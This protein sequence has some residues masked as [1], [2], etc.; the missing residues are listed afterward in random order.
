MKQAI[1]IH[2]TGG[3]PESF[4]TPWLKQQLTS[5]GYKVHTPQMPD[6]DNPRLDTWLP[7]LQENYTLTEDTLLI[8][9]SAGCPIILSWLENSLQ[10]INKAILVSGFVTQIND[11]VAPVIQDEYDY[12]KIKNQAKQFVLINSTRDP[13]SC[14]KHESDIMFEKL[15]GIQILVDGDSHFGSD[16]FN[17][18]CPHLPII[19]GHIYS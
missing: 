13:W 2:G 15:G 11:F 7:F 12:P 9:H 18:P 6:T 3:T 17:D 14:N 1:I 19:L 8:G 10:P 16:A 4:W 5:I